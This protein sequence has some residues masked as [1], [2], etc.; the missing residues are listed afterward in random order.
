MKSTRRV[1]RHTYDETLICH[2]VGQQANN[3]E[4]LN[5]SGVLGEGAPNSTNIA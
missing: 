4:Y 3:T 5:I 1:V 2:V